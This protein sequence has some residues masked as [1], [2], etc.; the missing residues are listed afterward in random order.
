MIKNYVTSSLRF[1][2]QNKAFAFI[3]ALSLSIALSVSFII[4]LYVVNEYSYDRCHLKHKRIFRVL[5]YYIDYKKPYAGTPF[6]LSSA[7]KDEFPQIEKSIS[8]K[9]IT[10]FKIKVNDEYFLVSDAAFTDSDV[11]DIFTFPLLNETTQ[12]KNLLEDKN[13]IVI[14]QELA[15][16]IFPGQEPIGKKITGILDN[17]D[18]LFIVKGIFG[19]FAGNSTF[20]PQCLMSGKLTVDAINKAYS[21]TNADKDWSQNLWTTWILLSKNSDARDLEKSFRAFELKNLGENPHFHYFLQNLKDVYLGSDDVGNTGL[22]GNKKNIRLFITIALLIVLVAAMNYII[23]STSVSSER[24]KEIG[25]R[26]T[27]GAGNSDIK[28]QLY[29][30]SVLMAI[31]T[32]PIA[33]FLMWF[34][35]PITG[36]LFQT[37]LSIINSNIPIYVLVSLILTLLIGIASGIYT[38]SI[39]SRLDVIN[40]VKNSI[41]S[42]KKKTVLRSILIVFQLIIFCSFVSSAL[43]IRSQYQYAIKRDPGHYKSDILLINLGRDFRGYSAF[44]NNIK[45]IPNVIQA[46]ATRECLPLQNSA[47]MM[48]DHFQGNEVNVQLETMLIDYNYL[49]TM[50]IKVLEGR[51]FSEEYGSDMTQAAMLNETAVKKLGI[52]DPIG[53]KFGHRTIIGVVKDFNLHSI[54]SE[55]PATL[56]YPTDKYILQ[57]AVRYTT[58]TLSTILPKLE[59]EWKKFAPDNRSFTY[60]TIEDLIKS[61]YSSEKNLTIL[62]TI[63]SLLTILIAASGLFGLTLFIAR[64]RTKEIG[65]KKV[66]GCSE[67]II[68]YAF[69]WNNLIL[70]IAAASFSA[71]V[72]IYFMTRWLSNFPYNIDITSWVFVAAFIIS[73]LIVQITAFVYLH[74][75][76]QINPVDALKYE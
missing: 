48:I 72:T 2:K 10:N 30:E 24:A 11:F 40:V 15:K 9:S 8:L 39:L 46:A 18:H 42:G 56:I 3:N 28:Y 62:V 12:T 74:R 23:L 47:T 21:I 41:Q 53:I 36:E 54:H 4:V 71:P 22:K 16:K 37:S 44:I 61:L 1:W 35:L 64:A 25:L 68:I 32:I 51:D 26:K 43:I 13:S 58:G 34:A 59:A 14:S 20:K 75:V 66:F 33:L 6:I 65:L 19:E 55:I 63:F 52:T 70:A 60:L 29:G 31:L 17:E 69:A 38:S 5:N 45:S 7:L 50:G 57:V 73:L 76:S 67:R 27:F 49:N